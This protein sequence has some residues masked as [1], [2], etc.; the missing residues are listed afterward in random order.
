MPAKTEQTANAAQICLLWDESLFWGVMLFRALQDLGLPCKI[1]RSSQI[2][3]GALQRY[4]PGVLLVPGG[5]ASRK[6]WSL[7][8]RGRQAIREYVQEKGVYFG[9]CGGAGLALQD[10]V[11]GLNLCSWGRKPMDQRLPNCSGH[12]R[13]QP[14]T[15]AG[16]LQKL[17][18]EPIPAP[19]WW[20]SQFAPDNQARVQVLARY[21]E[22]DQ[23]FWVADLPLQDLDPGTLHS[24]QMHYSIN[25]EPRLLHLE[26]A[27]IQGCY[28][29]GRFLLSYVHLESP[30]SK[31]ANIWLQK[32]LAHFCPDLPAL[33][34]RTIAQ[35]DLQNVQKIWPEPVLLRAWQDA[36]QLVDLGRENF[37]LCWRKP[38]LLGWRRAVPGFALNTV[39]ALLAQALQNPAGT[40]SKT[41]WTQHKHS[42]QALLQSFC[43]LYTDYLLKERL[44]LARQSRAP[45][46]GGS[47][48]L[49]QQRELLTGPFPGQSGLFGRLAN[50]LQEL[51]WHQMLD[52]QTAATH[53]KAGYAAVQDEDH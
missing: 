30:Q 22:P 44:H 18:V 42:L 43:Q 6:A 38:W 31:P 12:I 11:P 41:F 46:P 49:Q 33:Q 52:W 24:W 45:Q 37:L 34:Y 5:W 9:L 13:L 4:K 21:L 29:R 3:R 25:L 28:G 36:L 26:P 2:R 48:G 23:D 47:R 19:V 14:E 10:Q 1:L 35:W 32:I 51:L 20:P 40:Q 50:L 53:S 7:G 8:R 15:G 39:L 16:L 17:G 27:I